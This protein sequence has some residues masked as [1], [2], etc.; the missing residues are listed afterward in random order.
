MTFGELAAQNA[1][2]KEGLIAQL[3]AELAAAKEE[4]R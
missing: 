2:E 3:R 1:N 4:Q